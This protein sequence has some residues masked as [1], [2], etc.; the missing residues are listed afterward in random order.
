MTPRNLIDEIAAML[1]LAGL[2]DPL[3]LDHDDDPTHPRVAGLEVARGYVTL[4]V[5]AMQ[6]P[7]GLLVWISVHHAGRGESQSLVLSVR[8]PTPEERAL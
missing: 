2:D 5:E 1:R 4:D 8:Q 3:I 6:R 7:D